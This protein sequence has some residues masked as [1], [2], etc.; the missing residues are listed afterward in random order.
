MKDHGD[1]DACLVT[2]A[3]V[4]RWIAGKDWGPVTR[5]GA[6][7]AIKRAF[8]LAKKDHIIPVNNLAEMENPVPPVEDEEIDDAVIARMF[9]GIRSKG[10]R[11]F[12]AFIYETGC[13]VCEARHLEARHII[14]GERVVTLKS[15]TTNRTRKMRRIYLS[16]KA[17]QIIEARIREHPAGPL[18]RSRNGN[19]WTP[20]AINCQIRRLRARIGA[21]REVMARLLRKHWITDALVA[22]VPIATVAELAG[23]KSTKMIEDVYSKLSQRHE[24]LI[25]S[26]NLVRPMAEERTP[27]PP[28]RPDDRANP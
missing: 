10:F 4:H 16:D 17:R 13:R 5:H 14:L 6:I 21:G 18:F 11:D 20:S 26:V 28:R 22:G 8:R 2:P 24:H 23:H 27:A 7:T 9:A 1:D 25:K 12:I 3:V 19:A 15:K